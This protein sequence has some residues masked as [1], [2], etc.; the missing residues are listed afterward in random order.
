[1]PP[2]AFEAAFE[3]ADPQGVVTK[4]VIE[5]ISSTGRMPWFEGKT[6][7][8][9]GRNLWRFDHFTLLSDGAKVW[10]EGKAA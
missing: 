2:A 7:L 9:N 8:G 5:V 4:K 1:L 6:D 10:Q 3:L